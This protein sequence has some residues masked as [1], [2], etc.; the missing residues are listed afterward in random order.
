MIEYKIQQTENKPASVRDTVI[1][2]HNGVITFTLGQLESSQRQL[3]KLERE[4]QA[5]ADLDGAKMTNI[6]EHHP[7]VK[8]LSEEDRFT[9][10]LYHDSAVRKAQVEEKLKQVRDAITEEEK[11]LSDIKEQTGLSLE[12]ETVAE[13]QGSDLATDDEEEGGED[14]TT[15]D[16]E[17]LQQEG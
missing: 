14:V 2:K 15:S 13:D 9:V 5:Q 1:E 16:E 12:E 10:A 3:H 8:D 11:A 17:E 4:L 7:F 6:E